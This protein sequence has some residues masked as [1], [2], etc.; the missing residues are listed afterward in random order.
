MKL[1]IKVKTK[2]KED[3]IEQ[4][5]ENT[6]QVSVKEPPTQN[7]ANFAILKLISRHFRVPLASLRLIAGKSSK[8]KVIE[9]K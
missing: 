3:K 9:I 7:K 6:Y 2:A 5:S 4:I 8:N 1:N